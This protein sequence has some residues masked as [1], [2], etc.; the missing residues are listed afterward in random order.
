MHETR[1]FLL[2]LIAVSAELESLLCDEWPSV[3]DAL[4]D[5][6]ARFD[7]EVLT[8]D[9]LRAADQLIEQ[10]LAGPA[11]ALVRPMLATEPVSLTSRR[12]GGERFTAVTADDEGCLTLPIFY[13]TDRRWAGGDDP[14]EWYSGE[15]GPLEY[16]VLRVTVPAR[17]R[18]GEENGPR[19]WKLEFRRDP[20]RHILLHAIERMEE[21]AFAGEVRKAIAG[22]GEAELL[23]FVHGFNVSFA[24]SM[25]RAAQI[26][27]DLQFPGQTAV[28]SWASRARMRLY[29]ADEAT[30]EASIPHF[31]AFLELLQ[32]QT[33]ARAVH[34]V[35]HSMGNR[36]LTRVIERLDPGSLSA[37]S[38]VLGEVVFAAPDVDRDVF[39]QC[40]AAFTGRAQ[41]FTLYA[42]SN[43]LALKASKLF[44]R[45]PRAGDAGD[46]LVVREGIDTID[47]SM[48]DTSLFGLGHSYFSAK[49]S[50]LNDLHGAILNRLPAAKRF[51]LQS[52]LSTSGTY[53]SYR[54]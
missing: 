37:G 8:G 44:H 38:A 41:R 46:A 14:Q 53:W 51:D 45:H 11:A 26:A 34:V 28:Y 22:A 36:L 29:P 49:R 48:A 33:G 6:L 16:G 39:N 17:Y 12:G 52:A 7:D 2:S 10:L 9:A 47:A 4:A 5:L 24:A 19:W 43:D 23:V 42:S 13:G 32:T 15:R 54:E 30:I 20:R 21:Q 1:R 27:R 31:G 25:R 18:I 50:I 35:A 3:R 40:A